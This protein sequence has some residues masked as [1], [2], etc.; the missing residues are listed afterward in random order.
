MIL[1]RIVLIFQAACAAIAALIQFFFL[2]V[3]FMMLL[4]GI[5][6]LICV[7]HVFFT[8]FRVKVFAPIAWCKLNFNL[9][10]KIPPEAHAWNI[11]LTRKYVT[12]II[13]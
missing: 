1:Q 13:F 7:V 3:F 8:K 11:L 2:V 9:V 12:K 4:I 5:E 6:I 10:L